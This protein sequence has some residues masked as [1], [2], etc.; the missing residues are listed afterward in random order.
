M[1]DLQKELIEIIERL[2]EKKEEEEVKKLQYLQE[3]F[4]KELEE[5]RYEAIEEAD[6]LA[7]ETDNY[8][9]SEYDALRTEI[10]N[11]DMMLSNKSKLER[12]AYETLEKYRKKGENNGE[13]SI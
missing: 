3:D 13:I 10:K 5:K 12:I 4:W 1:N 7:N 9:R 11:F 2:I 8:A 6:L